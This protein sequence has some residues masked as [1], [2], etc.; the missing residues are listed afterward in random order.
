M[1]IMFEVSYHGPVPL[2]LHQVCTYDVVI[3]SQTMHP[4][5][6]S[7]RLCIAKQRSAAQ[8]G[9]VPSPSFC[10][11]ASCGAVRSLEHTAAVTTVV[12][13]VPGMI[14][15][16]DLCTCFVQSPFRFFIS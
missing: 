4:Q 5:L 6:S 11:A 8:C 10:G 2:I 15:I 7:A 9:A 16:P 1:P 3:G 14:Q 12:V 13:V